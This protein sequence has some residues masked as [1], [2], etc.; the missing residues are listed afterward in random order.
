MFCD[1]TTYHFAHR[2]ISENSNGN[3]SSAREWLTFA[4]K[5]HRRITAN[6]QNSLASRLCCGSRS[7]KISV[8]RK[9][10][11]TRLRIDNKDVTLDNVLITARL[12]VDDGLPQTPKQNLTSY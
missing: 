5:D 6:F 1:S 10:Y 12:E 4:A 3:V 9:S 2:V 11:G 7:Q 8:F